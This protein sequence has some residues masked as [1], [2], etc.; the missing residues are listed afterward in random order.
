[1][2]P[3]TRK[4][5]AEQ[6]IPKP[7]R[8]NSRLGWLHIVL[9]CAIIVC[10]WLFWGRGYLGGG[11]RLVVDPSVD[12]ADERVDYRVVHSVV[13]D[14]NDYISLPEKIYVRIEPCGDANAYY[15]TGSREITLCDELIDDF[16]KSFGQV[17]N[18]PVDIRDASTNA[19]V[20]IAIHEL[21]HALVDVLDIPITG[22]EED[23]ADQL[24]A[25][26]L[27]SSFDDGAQ[28]VL[29]GATWFGVI[30]EQYDL[31][32]G[33]FEGV[34]SLDVQRYYTLACWV[35]GSNSTRYGDAVLEGGL[36]PE[37]LKTC[38]DEYRRFTRSWD[39]L[40]RDYVR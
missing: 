27:I 22:K 3:R 9:F 34:H 20:F 40:L 18:N 13:T 24:S 21:G 23:V 28:F 29:D 1:M 5:Q 38:E 12:Q 17:Y 7:K 8:Q 19:L 35:Y 33:D 16:V 25:Y 32:E 15:D 4:S 11:I 39:V 37:R 14:I 30:S 26:L 2:Q 6:I 36:S 31:E 10:S